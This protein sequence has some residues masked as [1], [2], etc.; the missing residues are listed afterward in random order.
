[1][2]SCSRLSRTSWKNRLQVVAIGVA[3]LDD[4]AVLGERA[5]G[6]ALLARPAGRIAVLEFIQQRRH[7]GRHDQLGIGE[8]VHQEDL[9][10]VFE[11]DTYVEHRGLHSRSLV[12]MCVLTEVLRPWG[13]G[14]ASPSA[15]GL[16]K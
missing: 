7:V 14:L 3:A 8:R 12:V 4:E 11:G 10:L 2:R 16:M 5:D 6:V 13:G 9:V 1:M 15:A